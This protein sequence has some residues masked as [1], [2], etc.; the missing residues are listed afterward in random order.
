MSNEDM[1]KDEEANVLTS[2]FFDSDGLKIHYEIIGQG[3]PIILIHGWSLSIKS[4]WGDTGWV[5]TLT[6]IRR[7]IALDCRGHGLSD[8]PYEQEAYGSIN[9]AQDVLNLMDHLGIIKAD[10][11][12]YSMG[13]FIA[14]YL[15]GHYEERFS[16][17]I[18]GGI[19]DEVMDVHSI[20]NALLAEDPLQITN[21]EAKLYRLVAQLDPNNDLKALAHS[22]LELGPES[23]R[24]VELGG[25]GLTD[26]V[27][28]ILIING[29]KDLVN[30]DE[31]IAKIPS[32][33]F[34][35]IPRRDHI[36]VIPDKRFKRE[37]LSFLEDN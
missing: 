14:L 12:G 2:E 11:F 22:I 25:T 21:P 33:K 9:M 3:K 19:G 4:N 20:A 6:P 35:L 30:A 23:N 18:L 26:I 1:K 16:S 36:S 37:V 24:I 27:I 7:V 17:V 32:A 34:I 31:L 8:K 5:K 15:L 28:P 29:E 13:A 10:I